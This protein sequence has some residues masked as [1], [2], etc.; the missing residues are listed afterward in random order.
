MNDLKVLPSFIESSIV[1]DKM[2]N[3]ADEGVF[4]ETLRSIAPSIRRCGSLDLAVSKAEMLLP[5]VDCS[6]GLLL[7]L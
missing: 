5:C 3:V 2:W 6:E 1:A 4:H 7:P